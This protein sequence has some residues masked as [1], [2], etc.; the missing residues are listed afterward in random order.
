MT[1]P[2]R[3]LHKGGI[4]LA[5]GGD[6]ALKDSP[7]EDDMRGFRSMIQSTG[8]VYVLHTELFQVFTGVNLRFDR[9]LER[10]GYRKLPLGLIP[11]T[12]GR[13]IFEVFR[14]VKAAG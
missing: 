11:D 14:V 3:L 7:G 12:N 13:N 9:L 10:E 2:L 1:E 6:A 4:P 8:N 5:W